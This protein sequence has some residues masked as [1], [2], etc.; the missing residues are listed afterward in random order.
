MDRGSISVREVLYLGDL[1]TEEDFE[2]ISFEVTD[3]H[4][5][6][7]LMTADH[8]LFCEVITGALG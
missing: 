4:G 2:F 7:P 5:P 8:D 1:S 6:H 3:F